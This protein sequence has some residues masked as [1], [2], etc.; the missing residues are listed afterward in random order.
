MLAALQS[1]CMQLLAQARDGLPPNCCTASSSSN[2]WGGASF[3]DSGSIQ[4]QQ[5]QAWQLCMAQVQHNLLLV[6]QLTKHWQNSNV[7]DGY[8]L[9][10]QEY[11]THRWAGFAVVLDG[12]GILRTFMQWL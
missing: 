2:T 11:T 5:R 7:L 3:S 6:L 8:Q 1:H 4:Q 12:L 9:T 10:F